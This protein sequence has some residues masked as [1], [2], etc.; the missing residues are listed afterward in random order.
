MTNDEIR[1]A[2]VLI[3]DDTPANTALLEGLLRRWGFTSVTASTDSGDAVAL[4]ERLDPDLLLLDLHM[5]A[6]DGLE[7]LGRL[8]DR[9]R[10]AV[11]LPVIV[12]TADISGEAKRR[13]LQAGARDFLTK[14]LDHE[15]VRLRVTNLLTMRLAQRAQAQRAEVLESEVR[16]RT[17]HLEASRLEIVQRLARAAEHRD[18]ATG[19]HTARVARTAGL[20]ARGL[21]LPEGEIAEIA[22]AAPL[23]DVGKIG[24]SDTILLKPGRLTGEEFPWMKQHVRIGGQ[25]LAGSDSPLLQVAEQIAM[26]HHERWDGRGY[27]VGLAGENIPLPGRIVAVA[28]VFDALTHRRPYKDPWPVDRAVDEIA[29]GAGGQFDPGVVE[30]FTSL[31]HDELVAPLPPASWVPAGIGV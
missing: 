21:G 1:H 13:A 8:A 6:P 17:R 23:H 20:L 3:I 22:A 2:R 5:P 30:V 27:L 11:P 29:Q 4:C 31:D 19:Q 12:L 28:D 10:A 26:A 16:S 18:D 25:I 9:L 24:I 7:V 15:E 14:P